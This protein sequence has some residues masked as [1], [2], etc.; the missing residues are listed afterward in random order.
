MILPVLAEVFHGEK[1][2]NELKLIALQLIVPLQVLFINARTYKSYLAT[3]IFDEK[4]RNQLL[5][6]MVENILN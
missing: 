2:E 5:D 1:T 6:Q 3:D 4:Q